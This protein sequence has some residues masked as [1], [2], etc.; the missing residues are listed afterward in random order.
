[1]CAKSQRA[2]EHFYCTGVSL[3]EVKLVAVKSDGSSRGDPGPG[4]AAAV[5]WAFAAQPCE[6]CS[7]ELVPCIAASKCVNVHMST[8]SV[9]EALGGLLGMLTLVRW[10]QHAVDAWQR[11]GGNVHDV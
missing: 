4:G 3:D 5:L 6:T 9:A 11:D 1:M 8:S 10:V 7:Q 2:G